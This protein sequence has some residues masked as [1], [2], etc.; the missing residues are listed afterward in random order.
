MLCL[1]VSRSLVGTESCSRS[2]RGA[3]ESQQATGDL[4]RKNQHVSKQALKRTASFQRFNWTVTLKLSHSFSPAPRFLFFGLSSLLI[5]E[6]RTSSGPRLHSGS[7][8][9]DIKSGRSISPRLG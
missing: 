3:K 7:Q 4:S 8:S 5:L 6:A 9:S 1:L 2:R